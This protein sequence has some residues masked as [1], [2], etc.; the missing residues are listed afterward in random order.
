MA[1]EILT[2]A[3]AKPG[4]TKKGYPWIMK[5]TPAVWGSKEV[6]PN[7]IKFRVTGATIIQIENYLEEW[8]TTYQHTIVNENISG[9][10]IKIEVDPDVVSAAGT[11][12]NIK[13]KAKSYIEDIWGGVTQDFGVD[14][15]TF[16]IAKPVDL[17]QLKKEFA[18]I[19]N[20]RFAARRYRFSDT[21][22]NNAVMAGGLLE[23]TKAEAIADII[24]E[25]SL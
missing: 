18:D 19:F 13:T 5:E 10:R 14:F 7:W 22:V 17:V 4:L 20:D 8:L 15:V 25:V 24:D 9:Y 3:T 16:D 1:V 23:I 6:L 21:L 11:N 12:K 2:V